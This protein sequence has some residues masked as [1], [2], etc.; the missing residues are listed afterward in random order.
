MVAPSKGEFNFRHSSNHQILR[1]ILK[2]QSLEVG[3]TLQVYLYTHNYHIIKKDCSSTVD[4]VF[5]THF[6]VHKVMFL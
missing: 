6:G 5:R 3:I 2:R 1:I 4:Q